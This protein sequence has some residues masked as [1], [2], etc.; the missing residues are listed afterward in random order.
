MADA[1]SLMERMVAQTEEE[2]LCLYYGFSIAGDEVFC[3]EGYVNAEGA[4]EH[5]D[6]VGPLLSEFLKSAD[7]VR[8]EVHGP[9][10]ELERMREPMAELDPRFFILEY[11]FRR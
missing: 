6:R 11:G 4:L 7:L 10:A 2:P 1:Q 5:L 8:L 9:E 3:R